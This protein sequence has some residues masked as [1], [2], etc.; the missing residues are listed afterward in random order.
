VA[1]REAYLAAFHTAQALIFER[2]SRVAKT[3]KGVRTVFA[4]L[5]KDDPRID[6]SMVE[7]LGR[8]YDLKSRADYGV[9]SEAYIDFT[10]AKT[11]IEAAGSFVET[12]AVLLG[13]E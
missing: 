13:N 5:A 2:T 11:A 4:R 6:R 7:F 12:I 8:G 1:G 10:S 3:H 9:G